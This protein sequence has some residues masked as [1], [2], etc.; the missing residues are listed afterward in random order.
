MTPPVSLS[1]VTAA[2]PLNMPSDSVPV[3]TIKPRLVSTF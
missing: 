2:T 3:V 1:I